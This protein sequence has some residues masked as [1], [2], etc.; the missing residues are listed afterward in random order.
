M[1]KIKERAEARLL[2]QRGMSITDIAKKLNLS[3]STV[4]YWCRNIVLSSEQKR[5]L[6]EKAKHAGIRQFIILGEQKRQNRLTRDHAERKRGIQDVRAVS[7]RDLF[8]L[9]LGLYW[10]EGYKHGNSEL[11]FTN[12]DTTMIVVFLKWL[13]RTYAIKRKDL[14]LRVSINEMHKK[15]I[16]KVLTYWSSITHVPLS[17]FTKPTFIHTASKKHYANYDEYY[18]ILRV[19]VRKGSPLKQRILG[20]LEALH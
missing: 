18:G 16:K 4:S 11:G 15:R 12:S 13:K 19:K 7:D 6:Q 5:R 3:K 14:I 1:A 9:G 17:Q 2:R 20:S 8:F 10:G